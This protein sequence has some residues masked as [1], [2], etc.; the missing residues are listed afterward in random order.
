MKLEIFKLFGVSWKCALREFTCV[1][2]GKV[3]KWFAREMVPSLYLM[4]IL[5]HVIVFGAC[6]EDSWSS[7][8]IRWHV[9]LVLLFHFG[10]FVASGLNFIPFVFLTCAVIFKC[11]VVHASKIWNNKISWKLILSNIPSPFFF[12]SWTEVIHAVLICSVIDHLLLVFYPQHLR[13]HIMFCLSQY[14]YSLGL[15]NLR[16]VCCLCFQSCICVAS[17]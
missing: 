4:N 15:S 6:P 16:N 7:C 11:H 12:T 8:L 9:N 3:K 1:W 10:L 14:F 2:W 13:C 17:V 5:N